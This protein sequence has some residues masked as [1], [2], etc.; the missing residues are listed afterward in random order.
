M[1]RKRS[2]KGMR[3]VPGSGPSDRACAS[4]GR[5]ADA[6]ARAKKIGMSTKFAA[7]GTMG[8]TSVKKRT[9]TST[10]IAPSTMARPTLSIVVGSNAGEP[11]VGV[12]AAMGS[13][14]NSVR[15]DVTSA[16]SRAYCSDP[17][18]PDSIRSIIQTDRPSL[19]ASCFCVYPRSRRAAAIRLPTTTPCS[20]TG[21]E[22]TSTLLW[23]PGTCRTRGL[24][25]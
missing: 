20:D 4:T 1:R 25:V 3:K 2:E 22:L 14:S 7:R 6:V 12:G 8:T 18:V 23:R 11:T 16:I 15:T 13:S 17:T 9:T 19:S 5:N 24:R 21:C 10:T